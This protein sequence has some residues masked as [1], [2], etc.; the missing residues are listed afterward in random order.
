MVEGVKREPPSAC[1][2][3]QTTLLEFGWAMKMNDRLIVAFLIPFASRNIKSKW[4]TA[5]AWH[6]GLAADRSNAAFK[7]FQHQWFWRNALAPLR[8]AAFFVVSILYKISGRRMKAADYQSAARY[9]FD[10][11]GKAA[12]RWRIYRRR[13]AEIQSMKFHAG[14]TKAH[15]RRLATSD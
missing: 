3:S 13:I 15:R 2:Q 7:R 6:A 10:Y 9:W 12:G 4:E 11:L 1:Q 8:A 14:A 5:C